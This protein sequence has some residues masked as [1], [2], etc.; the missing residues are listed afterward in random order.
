[1]TQ[2][3]L[4]IYRKDGVFPPFVSGAQSASKKK[5]DLNP[6]ASFLVGLNRQRSATSTV[7]AEIIT[8][9]ILKRAGPVIFKNLLLELIAYRPIPVIC[10][11]R[12][13]S[14]LKITE[15]DN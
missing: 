10:R 12:G 11:A 14:S 1:M 8:E 13:P 4:Q 2:F 15:N 7:R 9:L 5:E 3:L 6:K